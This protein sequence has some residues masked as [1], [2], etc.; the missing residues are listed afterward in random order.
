MWSRKIG[1][2]IEECSMKHWMIGIQMQLSILQ[3]ILFHLTYD[4]CLDSVH[5]SRVDHFSSGWNPNIFPLSY[6]LDNRIQIYAAALLLHSYLTIGFLPWS[7]ST[8]LLRMIILHQHIPSRVVSFRTLPPECK[9]V[10]IFIPNWN[11]TASS[12]SPWYRW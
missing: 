7:A 2:R 4:I 11:D 6:L 5:T 1:T 3:I 9:V 8:T 12:I 10:C